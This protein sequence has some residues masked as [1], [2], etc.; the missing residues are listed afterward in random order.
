VSIKGRPEKW[1]EQA[2]ATGNLPLALGEA[3]ELRPLPLG[4]ALGLVCL[5]YEADDPRAPRAAARWAARLTL[6]R[7]DVDLHELGELVD[8]L[9]HAAS[10][11]PG[12]RGALA[13]LAQHYELAIARALNQRPR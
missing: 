4:P 8:A 2:V 12:A 7:P 1:L 5:L 3:A 10:Y 6:E 9:Q 13:A 11:P